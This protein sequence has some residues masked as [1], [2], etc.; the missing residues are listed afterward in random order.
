MSTV[1]RRFVALTCVLLLSGSAVASADPSVKGS[2]GYCPDGNGVT[3]VVDF[4]ELG[5]D[6]QIRC[7]PGE[8]ESGLAALENAGFIVEGTQRWGKA[9]VCR[10]EGKPGSDTEP[11]VNTPP[12]NAYWGY[13]HASNGGQW[14]YSQFGA[15][16]RKPPLGSFEGWSFSKDKTS[17]TNPPPRLAP[18]RP[19]PAVE[20]A[21]AKN[22]PAA[23][24]EPTRGSG[25]AAKWLAGQLVKDLLPGPAGPEAA[26]D[27]GL[28]VDALLGLAATDAD[29]GARQR[30]T[31][32]LAGNARNYT[33]DQW[34]LPTSRIGGQTAKLL[35]GAVAAG[36]DATDFGGLDLRQETL[37]LINGPE[38]G[39]WAGQLFDKDMP[40]NPTN[41]FGLSFAVLGLA[42]SGGAP[43][44]VVDFLA[45]QQCAAGG[46]RLSWTQFG[47]T[48]PACDGQPGAVLDPDST[49]MAVQALLL[50]AK[51]GAKGAADAATKG[52][53]WLEGIQGEDGGF[54]G[55]ATTA[56]TRNTNSTGLA[57]QALLAGGRAKSAD[58]AAAFVRS[59][60]LT[61]DNGGKATAQA[62]AIAWNRET[63]DEAVR[64]GFPT[65]PGR[66]DTWRRATAQAVLVLTGAPLGEL[67]PE[68]PAAGPNTRLAR[69]LTGKLVNGDHVEVTSGGQSFI[70]YGQ[71]ADVA[72]GLLLSG[73]Q[74]S[75]LTKVLAFLDKPD[76]VTA[77]TQGR[78]FDP[79]GRYAGA[80]AKLALLFALAGKD[81][82]KVGGVDLIAQLSALQGP[83]GR[84]ANVSQFGNNANTFGQ[85]FG[86]LALTAAGD[87]ARADK[88]AAALIAAR[89]KDNTVPVGFPGADGCAIGTADAT[90]LA[91]QALN[92]VPRVGGS[93]SQERKAALTAT[94][95][96][97]E[98]ARQAGG[99]WTGPGG[100]NV[101][102][103]AYATMGLLGVRQD[104]AKSRD[105]LLSLQRQDG[106]LPL[107]P[108]GESNLLASAQALP[109]TAGKSFLTHD[110]GPVKPA[111]KVDAPPKPTSTEPPPPA[112][113]EP[114]PPRP[115]AP[116]PAPGATA[117]TAAQYRPVAL[118][119]TGVEAPTHLLIGAL[120][121]GLGMALVLV[122]RRRRRA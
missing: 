72:Y 22:K 12:A 83:D 69:Y 96:A 7:A 111:E 10:I 58:R 102:S 6:T 104:A 87:T 41:T 9:F 21:T 44:H 37:N 106:G 4:Q 80:T 47:A 101:N 119:R 120:L 88:A 65:L 42:R 99:A 66:R 60:Q 32:A 118:A 11:C 27:L 61:Q 8:Q 77:Y 29:P 30:L 113:E 109:A 38:A 70:D 55:S 33:G 122:T 43:Q 51:A 14:T 45:K 48:G 17:T 13:W 112:T 15:T 98:A 81:P 108:G 63:F 54:G 16:G 74:Q 2:A 86:V 18:V 115:D 105:W 40:S 92:A 79:N 53:N 31:A 39:E 1:L 100:E 97:L 49:G 56:N 73:R 94:V 5:G 25:E 36:A 78:P 84:F 76:S 121:L 85:S 107:N 116:Q 20:R 68:Q 64:D 67:G 75:S 91:L 117:A 34:G 35:F 52:L 50:A 82:R 90:G 71:T 93:L 3:V 26:P 89:C 19:A 62:G 46:F 23:V 24:D 114:E 28:S 95:R 103:T 59:L 110:G 57:G